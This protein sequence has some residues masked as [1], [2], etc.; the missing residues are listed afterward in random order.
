MSHASCALTIDGLAVRGQRNQTILEV[1]RENGIPIPTLCFLEGLSA[2]GSCRLCMVELADAPGLHP[3]C[4]TPIRDGLQV[5]TQSE[6]LHRYRRA[7]IQLLLAERNHVCS[8]CVVNGQCELQHLART[9][10][11]DHL[12]FPALNPALQVDASHPRFV[13]DP[14]RC[15][16][17]TR[18]V[19]V[20]AEIEGAHT[21]DVKNRGV[22]SLIVADLD[23][24]WGQS[25]TCTSCG[26]C[27][28]VC[29]T[30]ALSEQGKTVATMRKDPSFLPTLLANRK[31]EQT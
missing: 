7:L 29:P 5:Q 10:G 2:V 18:C 8:V 3:A 9:L 24:P 6:R 1:A 21:W 4:V 15:I 27:V 16:L 30:G 14:N 25:T 26:K 31:E 22:Q 11:I 12:S 20:C 19:R 17:C 28:Q 23:L 13:L